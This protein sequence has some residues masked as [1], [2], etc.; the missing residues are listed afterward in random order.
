MNIKVSGL[1]VLLFS[2]C[3]PLA[4]QRQD[5]PVEVKVANMQ[6][7]PYGVIVTLRAHHSDNSV[8][9][10]IGYSEGQ[11]ISRAMHHQ[12]AKRPMSHDLF[13]TFLD[14]NGWKVQKVVIRG[15]QDGTFLADLMMQKD[16]ETQVYD[17]RPSDA[18]AI[19]LRYDAR[20]YVNPQVFEQQKKDQ[21]EK[22]SPESS[23]PDQLKL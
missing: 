16:K 15:I 18:L 17:A 21:E 9:L 11:S 10:M 8:Q 3:L 7:T 20:V 4:A 1:I 12:N 2:L 6:P 19:G 5:E 14:H 23:E 13:K 22:E